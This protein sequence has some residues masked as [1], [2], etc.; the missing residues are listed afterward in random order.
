MPSYAESFPK[1]N[2]RGYTWPTEALVYSLAIIIERGRGT[3][4]EPKGRMRS[5]CAAAGEPG[6][7]REPQP[8]GVIGRLGPQ[9][10]REDPLD[11]SP[12]S[13]ASREAS[14]LSLLPV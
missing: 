6:G 1:Y 14:A 5:G 9:L 8:G 3:L 2:A 11:Q 4:E 7:R 12:G 13:A 10:A